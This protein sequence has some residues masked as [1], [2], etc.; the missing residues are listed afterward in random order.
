MKIAFVLFVS[1]IV[2]IASI[3]SATAAATLS[4]L[5][6]QTNVET[7]GDDPTVGWRNT[8]PAKTYDVSHDDILGTDGYQLFPN[9]AVSLPTYATVNML[10]SQYPGN[11]SYALVDDPVHPGGPDITSGAVY[12]NG[13]AAGT[14]SDL[15]TF[16]LTGTVPG[17]IGVS[18]MVDNFDGND[19]TGEMLR[20]R[21]TTGGT[22]DSGYS[23]AIVSD[24]NPDW[25]TFQITGGVAGDVFTVSELRPLALGN[26]GAEQIGGV[27]FDTLTEIPEPSTVA[28]SMVIGAM[29]LVSFFRMRRRRRA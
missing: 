7:A 5:G 18:I 26:A 22:A 24:R 4:Y 3:P 17:T 12:F 29:G 15:F 6:S 21:Q 13:V 11:G 2:S 28:G 20:V 25:Y 19:G 1:T 10:G 14:E 9:N 27:A 16:T 23:T 8:T